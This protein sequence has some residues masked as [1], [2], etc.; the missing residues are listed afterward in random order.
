MERYPVYT[1]SHSGV[2]RAFVCVYIL[3]VETYL[4]YLY[5]NFLGKDIVKYET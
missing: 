4:G 2:K 5:G 1:D 3:Y